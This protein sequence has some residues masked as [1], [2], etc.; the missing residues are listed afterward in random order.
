MTKILWV[1]PVGPMLK[2][3]R[4]ER[5]GAEVVVLSEISTPPFW[6]RARRELDAPLVDP[7]VACWKAAEVAAD[8][9]ERLGLTHSKVGGYEPPPAA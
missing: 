3:F 2:L 1:N 8:L 5:D 4:R 6:A 9:Y 7:G